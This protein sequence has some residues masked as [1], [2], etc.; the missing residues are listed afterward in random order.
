ML[1]TNMTTISST[2]ASL[3]DAA[4]LAESS[5]LACRERHATAALVAALAEMDARRLYLGAGCS[6]LFTYCTQVLHLSEHAAYGRIEAARLARRFPAVLDGLADGSL[7]LTAARLLGA[8][9]TERNVMDLLSAARYKP[10]REVEQ[11]VARVR[12]LPA[13]APFVRKLP[14]PRETPRDTGPAAQLL[15]AAC[16]ERSE[17]SP[18]PVSLPPRPSVVR[19]L[20]AETYKVQFTL[21]AAGHEHLRRAQDLLRHSIPSGDVGLVM[22]RALELLVQDVERRKLAAATRPRPAAPTR[23]GARH[24]PASVRR[25][26]WRRDDGRCAF[27]GTAGR[28]AERGSWSSTT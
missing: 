2:V 28:C 14:Q 5:T 20:S 12:P 4:L 10:K 9:L 7:T 24:I 21:S 8:V 16:D 18:R 17:P 6:S 25:E 26:V 15:V 13:V 19:P 11:L 22:E 1:Q 27:A 23:A 3:S